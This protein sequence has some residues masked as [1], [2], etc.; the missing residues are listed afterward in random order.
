MELESI[1]NQLS[2][3]TLGE[4]GEL[5][6]MLREKWGITETVAP[7]MRVPAKLPEVIEDAVEVGYFNLVLRDLGPK[8]IEVIKTLRANA[9]LGLKEAKELVETPNAVL[10]TQQEK[11][12]A[13]R[14]AEQF[15]GV[16]AKVELVSA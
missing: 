15:F 8:K 2:N 1:V 16:G 14:L 13:N 4:A 3:L 12:I 6:K 7:L 5:A 10:F 11:E 9:Q